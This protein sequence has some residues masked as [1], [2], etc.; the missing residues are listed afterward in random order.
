MKTEAEIESFRAS[1]KD[2]S[3]KSEYK[4]RLYEG[5]VPQEF[6]HV[7]R[8]DVAH[9]VEAF[10]TFVLPYRQRIKTAYKHGYSMLFTGDN[11]TGKS[12]FMSYLLCR[13]VQH[14]YSI[15]YTTLKQLHSNLTNFGDKPGMSQLHHL[16]NSDFVGIDELGK[17]HTKSDFLLSELEDMLKFRYSEALPTLLAS[18]YSY[19]QL[20]DTY[21]PTISSMWEGR[22]QHVVMESG[23]FRRKAKSGMRTKMGYN[24]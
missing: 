12:M 5:C 6:W 7:K 19:D 9:N 24:V 8:T 11:G 2:A 10:N 15:Y 17:E 13:A 20:C 1:L 22:F 16:L 4:V 18:N 14:G 23:D 21:G 3:K